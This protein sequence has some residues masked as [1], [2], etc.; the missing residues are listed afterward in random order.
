MGG[1]FLIV[2]ENSEP[3]FHPYIGPKLPQEPAFNGGQPN[4][5]LKYMQISYVTVP[6]FVNFDLLSTIWE[7][8]K[9]GCCLHGKPSRATPAFAGWPSRGTSMP[10]LADVWFRYVNFYGREKFGSEFGYG[11]QLGD[12]VTGY[13][14]SKTRW[15]V[16]P[17]CMCFDC[18][19]L[20]HF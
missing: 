3:F 12:L 15:V 14:C 2:A 16:W 20:S 18:L 19:D 11:H 5:Y 7:F 10:H 9:L 6:I 13:S 1:V 8:F 17:P 4:F